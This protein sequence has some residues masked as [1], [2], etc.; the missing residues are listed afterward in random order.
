[1]F[2][3]TLE[4]FPAAFVAGDAFDIEFIAPC[5][6]FHR[7][8]DG[9][10]PALNSLTSLTPLQGRVSV[11]FASSLFHLFDEE[12]QYQLATRVATLLSPLPGSM[13]FGSQGGRPEKGIRHEEVR[14]N[15]GHRMFCHSPDSW[16]ELW[17]GKIFEKGTV[18]VKAGLKKLDQVNVES[19]G[20]DSD[21]YVIWWSVTRL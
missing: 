5:A 18:E 12:K 21:F 8:P 7:V 1:M 17:N 6:P 2:K 13:I 11:I 3:S 19:L 20:G 16:S 10:V 9:D 14:T 15:N 4:S